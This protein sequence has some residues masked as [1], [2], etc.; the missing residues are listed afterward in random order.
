[1]IV[2]RR[3][4]TAFPLALTL[5]AGCAEKDR[6]PRERDSGAAGHAGAAGGSG[7]PGA[8]AG[9]EA[10]DP[11]PGWLSEA[12]LYADLADSEALAPG[13]VEYR[14]LFELWADA[15]EKRRFLF[16]PSG[17]VID[18]SDMDY[19]TFPVGTR[20]FK[21]FTTDGVRVETRMLAKAADGSWLMLGF[22]WNAE[23]TDAIAVP[24]G[25]ENV[26]GTQH[27]IPSQVMCRECHENMPDT[28]LGVGAVQLS[29][30]LGGLTLD[31]L[32][33][34]GRLTDVPPAPIE[35]PGDAVAQAALGYLH[36]NCGNCHNRRSGDFPMVHLELFL[37]VDSL[38]DVEATPSYRTTVGVPFEGVPP[39]PDLAEVRVA[40]GDP[41]GSALYQR[42]SVREVL[43]QMPPLATEIPDDDGLRSVGAWITALDR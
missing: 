32:I 43:V 14:P 38:S 1:M 8:G 25:S 37:E 31:D 12:G 4:A 23:G 3:L 24:R 17:G 41:E 9:G 39:S 15:A 27:D 29:H 34:D 35:L 10:T 18:S 20:A 30:T 7:S 33:G 2:P 11:P 36:A 40:P 28:L 6:R 19:W 5:A 13:V 42:M 21:E 22:E 16:L 26:G